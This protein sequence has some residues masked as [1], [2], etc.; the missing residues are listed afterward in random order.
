VQ[1][2]QRYDGTEVLLD[3]PAVG[4]FLLRAGKEILMDLAPSSLEDEVRADL[5]GPV[6]AVL[7]HQRGITPLHAS[8]MDVANGCVAFVG[9]SG[10]GK[11]TL[12]ATLA[13]RGHEIIADDVCFLQ[14]GTDGD[15]QTWPGISRIRLWEDA[16]AGLGFDGPGVEREIYGYNKYFIP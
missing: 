13:Q 7:C 4:R 2:S 1:Y 15:V 12:V 5:L 3:F 16:R 8:A 10:A 14:L 9:D 11:S 6:F